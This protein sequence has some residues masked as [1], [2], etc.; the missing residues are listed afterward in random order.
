MTAPQS[1]G[2]FQRELP[3]D[4]TVTD[5]DK[6]RFI[7]RIQMDK[8]NPTTSASNIEILRLHQ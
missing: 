5:F 6:G 3:S 4:L 7:T 1:P 8:G 2:A